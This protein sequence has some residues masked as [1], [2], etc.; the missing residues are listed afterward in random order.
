[1]LVLVLRRQPVLVLGVSMFTSLRETFESSRSTSTGWRLSTSTMTPVSRILPV[2]TTNGI[3]HL[4]C[5]NC[6]TDFMHADD[7]DSFL[8]QHQGDRQRG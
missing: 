6:L 5:L 8:G 1:M 3:K 7:L 2:D 4:K